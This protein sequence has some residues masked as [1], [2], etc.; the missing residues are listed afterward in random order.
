MAFSIGVAVAEEKGK[1]SRFRFGVI[2]G[3]NLS[4][5]EDNLVRNFAG[6]KIGGRAEFRLSKHFFLD[7]SL[8]LAGKGE[9]KESN[10][11][12][13]NDD[14]SVV[15]YYVDR[16]AYYLELPVHIGF[17]VKIA[18]PV[19]LFITLGPYIGYGLFGKDK[20]T[21]DS[22]YTNLYKKGRESR[23]FDYGI[24]VKVGAELF[25]KIHLSVG[26]DIGFPNYRGR[27]NTNDYNWIMP[28]T[29]GYMF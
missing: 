14:L 11:Y 27:F 15:R 25:N 29:I 28:I 1:P 21:R 13:I 8:T 22:G 9:R 24:G 7:A 19:S 3:I 5:N 17:K 2:G 20:D 26:Y 16:K 12:S 4:G 10:L 6:I 18:K 23:R